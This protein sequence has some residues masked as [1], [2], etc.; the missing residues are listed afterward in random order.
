M[1]HTEG[2]DTSQAQRPL[3]HDP[4]STSAAFKCWVGKEEPV[5]LENEA[6]REIVLCAWCLFDQRNENLSSVQRRE[7]LW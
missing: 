1:M 6:E 5:P 4:E 7:D 3:P 2:L